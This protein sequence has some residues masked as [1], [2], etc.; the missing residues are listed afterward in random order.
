V[1]DTNNREPTNSLLNSLTPGRVQDSRRQ[2]VHTRGVQ[3]RLGLR[4]EHGAIEDDER[5]IIL[6]M[7]LDLDEVRLAKDDN[8]DRRLVME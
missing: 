1:V 5:D 3:I 2:I 6:D 7:V 8:L 4:A